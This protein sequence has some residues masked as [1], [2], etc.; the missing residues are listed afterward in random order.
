[1]GFGGSKQTSQSYNQ[2][3]PF[4]Q[5]NLGDQVGYTG[6]SNSAIASLL[7]LNG[8]A[9]TSGLDS[10]LNSSDYNFTRNQG[11]QGITSSNAAKGLLGSGSALKA[12]TDYS[13]GLAST[14]L[15]KYLSHLTSLSD[16]GLKAGQVLS[17]AGNTSNTQ[18][19]STS[20]SLG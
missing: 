5:S 6:K 12:I 2:A 1:M 15:D 17:D 11:L 20:L 9:D 10:Y 3:Y 13:S 7:G 8:A 18:S 16:S 19:K 4:L 14:Y